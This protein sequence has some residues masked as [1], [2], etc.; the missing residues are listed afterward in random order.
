M[1]GFNPVRTRWGAGRAWPRAGLAGGGYPPPGHRPLPKPLNSVYVELVDQY[2]VTAPPLQ[3]ALQV[4][5]ARSGGAVKSKAEDAET[6]LRLS[7]LSEG[8]EVLSIGPDGRAIE[9]R[10]LTRVTYSLRTREGEVL[11]APESQ[12]V[13]RDYS[14]SAQQILPKESEEAR[15]RGYIQ[16]SLAELV[17]L[18][19]ELALSQSRPG[20]ALP[21]EPA[22]T[23]DRA[24]PVPE[25][26]PSVVPA[27][28][29]DGAAPG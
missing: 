5:L 16:D 4:R 23:P 9:Y 11:I 14:F 26:K 10:L 8:R 2:H 6:V 13:S 28:P 3:T 29:A 12:T 21:A 1:A 22:T 18:R 17:L 27:A 20:L 7:D 15:L 25:F 24:V 19:L